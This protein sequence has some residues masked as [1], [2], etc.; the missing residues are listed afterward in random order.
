[1]VK[2]I[3]FDLLNI[4]F[5]ISDVAYKFLF[6]SFSLLYI[7][8]DY[9]LLIIDFIPRKNTNFAD[10]FYYMHFSFYAIIIFICFFLLSLSLFVIVLQ[11]DFNFSYFATEVFHILLVCFSIFLTYQVLF[12]DLFK[13]VYILDFDYIALSNSGSQNHTPSVTQSFI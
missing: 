8:I 6:S 10:T 12:Q 7:F 13:S 3:I 11:W 1:M 9:I 5:F 4:C 2:I